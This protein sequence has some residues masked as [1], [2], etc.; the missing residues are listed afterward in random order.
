MRPRL[1]MIGV[2]TALT[3][4]VA[5]SQCPNG[6]PPPCPAPAVHVPAPGFSIAVLPFESR[7]AD[8]GDAY[9]AEGMAEEV[10]NQ[11]ARTGRLQVKARTLVAAQWRRTP[12]ALE[13]ARQLNVAWV[14]HGNVRHA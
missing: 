8:A 4:S 7:S 1:R 14:V 13:A 9:L 10:A 12:D 3:A 5:H 11:L 2:L 6:A